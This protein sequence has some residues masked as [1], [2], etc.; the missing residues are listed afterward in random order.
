MD[1]DF[2]IRPYQ[3]GDR[4]AVREI[5]WQTAFRGDPA[6]TFFED[7]ELFEDFL[8]YYF[9]DREPRSSFVADKAGEVVGYII[10]AKDI[11][12][13]NRFYRKNFIFFVIKALVRGAFLRRKS[14]V[15]IFSCLRSFFNGEFRQP[16]FS[17]EYPAT[18]HINLKKDH[19]GGLVG[20]GL[21]AAYTEYL[22]R[23]HIRG[24]HLATISEE[25]CRFFKQQGFSLVFEQKRSCFRFFLK[26]DIPV[27][28]FAKKIG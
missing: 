25:A 17:G 7:K 14:C 23:E 15:F 24:V 27:Y 18:L 22:R 9:T 8:T 12:R 20:A 28:I 3:A 13:V 16:D 26:I 21:M 19:R 1:K 2:L 4:A 11:R 10:G 6:D 5:S